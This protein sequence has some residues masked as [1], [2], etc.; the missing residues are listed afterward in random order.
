MSAP[1]AGAV[2]A[3][4]TPVALRLAELTCGGKPI[5]YGAMARELGL[6]MAVLTAALEELMVEDAAAGRPYRSA[7]CE[8]RLERGMPAPGFFLAAE[9]LGR[10]VARTPEAIGAERAA[11]RTHPSSNP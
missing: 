4:L 9:A 11:L 5:T 2:Q 1:D 6:R 8:A 3:A 7:M 10:P